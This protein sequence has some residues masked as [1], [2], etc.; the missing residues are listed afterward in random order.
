MHKVFALVVAGLL[1]AAVGGSSAGAAGGTTCK[2]GG[3]TVTFTPPLPDA[4]STKTVKDVQ[5]RSG[6]ISGCS[7]TVKSGKITGVSPRSTGSNCATLQT[8][9]ST[10]TKVIFTVRWNIGV[11]STIAA[12]LKEIAHVTVTT[13]TVSG[14][15][16]AGLFKGSKLSGK[17]TYTLP[18]GGC[19]KGH[20]LA[21]VTYTDVGSIVIK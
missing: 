19:S 2:A 20:P 17:S 12:Q 13:Q 15:V 4:T 8:W 10:P 18:K 21:K 6:S 11:S 7:G 1:A 5:K 9:T 14:G 3:G 16:T